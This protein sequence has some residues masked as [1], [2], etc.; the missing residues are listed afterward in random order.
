MGY[1]AGFTLY[2][3][4]VMQPRHCC[5]PLET[6]DPFQFIEFAVDE[7]VLHVE[8]YFGNDGSFFVM[9]GLMIHTTHARYGPFGVTSGGFVHEARGYGLQGFRGWGNYAIDYIGANFE[10]C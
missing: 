2:V 6:P 8:F 10:R 9:R 7:H 5:F 1:V 4:D 3:N